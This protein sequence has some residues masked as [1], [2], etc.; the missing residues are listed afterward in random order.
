MS[1][2]ALQIRREDVVR[3]ARSLLGVPWVHQG[4]DPAYGVDCKGMLISMAASFNYPVKPYSKDYRRRSPG[5]ELRAHLE[6]EMDEIA[7]EEV[8]AGDCVLIKFPRDE[9]ARHVGL[10]ADGLYERTIIHAY[11]PNE[12]K[13]RVLEEPFRR[14]RPYVVA[15][16]RWKGIVD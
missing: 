9:E 3:A 1:E 12:G 13:G 5:A 11:E 2:M 6:S 16:F 7:V 14:W 10:I 4:D 15:A 8:R